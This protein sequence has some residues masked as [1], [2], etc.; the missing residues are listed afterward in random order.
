MKNEYR[1]DGNTI[2]ISCRH[3]DKPNTD[4]PI[5]TSDFHIADS[6]PG[7]WCISKGRYGTGYVS[8]TVDYKTV[9]LH[10]HLHGKVETGFEIDHKDGDSLN[11]RRDNLQMLTCQQNRA[12]C[13]LSHHARNKT[14]LPRN[15]Y[16][17]VS[18]N[19]YVKV[20]RHYIGTY[21]SLEIASMR[22]ANYRALMNFQR[23]V[24]PFVGGA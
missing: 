9:H 8:T 16:R 3:K 17:Q 7:R 10:Q 22:A 1:T 6:I 5:S 11:N 13:K 24:L 23:L 4:V 18:G 21:G 20:A 14:G 2:W 15:V 12:K 19:Y